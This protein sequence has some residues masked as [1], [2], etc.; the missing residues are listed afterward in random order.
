[1]IGAIAISIGALVISGHFGLPYLTLISPNPPISGYI[2]Y[3]GAIIAFGIIPL[4]L[5]I[6]T[7]I[8]FIGGYK[9]S[10]KFKRALAGVWVVSFMIFI[11]TGVFTM[12]N[13]VH[14]ATKT[15]LLAESQINPAQPL[16]IQLHTEHRSH[17]P[18]IQFGRYTYLTNGSLY[19]GDDIDVYFKPTGEEEPLKIV[20]T[21]Y[22]RGM[23]HRSAMH[24]MKYP[25]HEVELSD[26]HIDVDEFYRIGKRDKYRSQKL[27]YDISIPIGTKV[28]LSEPSTIF[29][30][31]E[32][33]K[34]D[35]NEHLWVMTKEG[36]E[37]SQKS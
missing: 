18:M 2:G 8:N 16:E 23:N 36:L 27:R 5:L 25:R 34:R 14:D 11:L 9:T 15:E 10:L 29:R 33:R 20:K 35:V 7:A 31:R 13:F 21:T 37:K 26:N 28:S 3:Y 32:F 12:R 30:E 4:I 1:M 17:S 22:S 19:N 24:N 6:K